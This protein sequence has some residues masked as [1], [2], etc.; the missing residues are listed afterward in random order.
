MV[1]ASEL[2]G[3]LFSNGFTESELEALASVAVPTEW[4]EGEILFQARLVARYFHLLR[5]G[6]VLLSYP[7]GRSIPLA[8]SGHGLGWSSLVS[9]FQ[10]TASAICLTD[11]K[12]YQFM[13]QEMYRLIQMD[14][15]FAQSLMRKIAHIM[16]E[17]KP[18]YR[19]NHS[20][21]E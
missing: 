6:T 3:C 9:P 18:Y 7:D 10:Y 8:N 20:A 12:T 11:V 17:R 1:N 15:N 21:K 14:A 13:G 16:E 5:S 4:K 2:K 19:Q